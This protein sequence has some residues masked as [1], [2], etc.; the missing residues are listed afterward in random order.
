M[1]K[2][3]KFEKNQTQSVEMS[4]KAMFQLTSPQNKNKAFKKTQSYR[5]QT[6]KFKKSKKEKKT[7]KHK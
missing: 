2:K 1:F 3:S 6:I 5:Y 7:L 4:N